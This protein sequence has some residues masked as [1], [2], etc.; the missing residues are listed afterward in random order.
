MSVA[1]QNV[2]VTIVAL[3]AIAILVRRLI[4]SRRATDPACSNCASGEPCAPKPASKPVEPEVRPLVL[5]KN[6]RF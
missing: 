2:V 1:L 3:A 5:V 4:G 6:K